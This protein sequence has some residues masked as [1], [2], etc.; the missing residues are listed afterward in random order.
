[1]LWVGLFC[2]KQ[3]Q[4]QTIPSTHIAPLH[5]L[6]KGNARRDEGD[7]RSPSVAARLVAVA[8][9]RRR[10]RYVQGEQFDI[11]SLALERERCVWLLLNQEWGQRRTKKRFF[12]LYVGRQWILLT[13]S[14]T[15]L[16]GN[17]YIIPIYL[18]RRK[19]QFKN[20]NVVTAFQHHCSIAWCFARNVLFPLKHVLDRRLCLPASRVFIVTSINSY[21]EQFC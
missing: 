1:M 19:H 3:K 7:G 12:L 10:R 18:A 17:K 21:V 8:G 15:S 4:V 11:C 20:W 5:N 14:C 13:M 2:K 6:L 16:D 9:G